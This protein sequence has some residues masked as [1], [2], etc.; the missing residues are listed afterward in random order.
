MLVARAIAASPP[1]RRMAAPG[2]LGL[3]LRVPPIPPRNRRASLIHAPAAGARTLPAAKVKAIRHREGVSHT[4][5]QACNKCP[6][7]C[8]VDMTRGP[9]QHSRYSVCYRKFTHWTSHG[10]GGEGEMCNPA[11]SSRGFRRRYGNVGERSN[12]SRSYGI[13]LCI[14]SPVL[15]TRPI[16]GFSPPW[17]GPPS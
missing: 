8:E 17:A 11:R 14:S 10:G 2:G 12:I 13:L 15:S 4:C 3:P 16:R 6:P 1:P 9:R 7:S 5:E